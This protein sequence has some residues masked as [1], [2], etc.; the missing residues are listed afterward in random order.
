MG[1]KTAPED[2]FFTPDLHCEDAAFNQRVEEFWQSTHTNTVRSKRGNK[3][4]GRERFF[5]LVYNLVAA[6]GAAVAIPM[7]KEDVEYLKTRFNKRGITDR[8]RETVR[9][10]EKAGLLF[11]V[12]GSPKSRKRTT[13][14]PAGA[15]TD[16]VAHLSTLADRLDDRREAMELRGQSGL[17]DYADDDTLNLWRSSLDDF[18]ELL[19]TIKV[20]WHTPDKKLAQPP[21][22]KYRR[23]FNRDSFDCGGRLYCHSVQNLPKTIRSTITIDG[24]AT[25][26]PDFKGLHPRILYL[27]EG[28][29]LPVDADVYSFWQDAQISDELRSSRTDEELRNKAKTV[30]LT[31]LNAKTRRKACGAVK[32][33]EGVEYNDVK[34]LYDAMLKHHAPIANYFSSDMGIRLQRLDSDIMLLVLSELTARGI[35]AL[36]VHDSV[37]CRERD[38]DVVTA[39][40]AAASKLYV[41]VPLPTDP[42]ASKVEVSMMSPLW[43]GLTEEATTQASPIGLHKLKGEAERYVKPLT[44]RELRQR[45]RWEE[46]MKNEV[47]Y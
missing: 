3:Q 5:V 11:V 26:E 32:S 7:G 12:T 36:P 23:V 30:Q 9:K 38:V 39:L 37:I 45:M 25:A 34:A 4:S 6:E 31:A 17:V 18:N 21:K 22:L 20:S 29:K 40:M 47:V 27:L 8:F 14:E 46:Q 10:C 19:G 15:L 42:P 1:E 35:P 33:E 28:I 41:G 43:K 16:L 13:L 24:E 2:Y 44:Q